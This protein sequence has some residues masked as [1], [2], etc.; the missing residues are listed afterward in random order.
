MSEQPIPESPDYDPVHGQAEVEVPAPAAY[1]AVRLLELMGHRRRALT[2]TEI[3]LDLGLAKSTVSNL[4]TSLAAAGM[5]RHSPRGWLLGYKVLELSRSMLVSS[6]VV[7]EFRRTAVTLQAL[8]GETT[9]L[10]VLEGLDVL[11]VARNDGH[12]PVRFVNEIGSRMPAVVTSLGKSMLASLDEL[13][14]ERR[15][16]RLPELPRLTERSHR[17]MA[18]LHHDLAQIRARGYAVDDEQNTV[19]VM[20]LGVALQGVTTPTAVSVSLVS[21]RV[22][23]DARPR[24]VADLQVLAQRL[25]RVDQL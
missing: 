2:I 1:R 19:G 15:L 9:V 13:E 24:L 11:Y 21:R 22:Q 8:R 4:L 14:L 18:A 10:A 16:S 12:Q 7:T 5:V 23:A 20:C 25:R 3:G 17:S 6:D